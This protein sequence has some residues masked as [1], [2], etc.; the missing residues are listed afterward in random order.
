LRLLKQQRLAEAAPVLRS[1]LALAPRD[2]ALW[3]NYGLTLDKSNDYSEAATCFEKSLAISP[4]QPDAW[5]LLGLAC[6]KGGDFVGA[7]AAY[8]KTLELDPFHAIAWQCLGLLKEEEK[9]Y[10]AAIE[11][12]NNCIR[13]GGASAPIL[14]NLGKLC[15]Q[16]GRFPE[17]Y[18][19]YRKALDLESSNPLFRRM[20]RKARFLCDVLNLVPIEN[21]VET[22]RASFTPT[23]NF[24]EPDLID[25]FDQAI[26]LLA[27]C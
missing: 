12:F 4:R 21:T 20:L 1:A 27:A 25:L 26:A 22:Y 17:A 15:F 9:D 8:R 18:D 13:C 23:E 24:A 19:A 5:L 10:A 6:K 11:Y 2:P 3:I 16:T 14:A 7:E